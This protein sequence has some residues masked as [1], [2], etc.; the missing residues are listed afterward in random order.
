MFKRSVIFLSLS[1]FL[2]GCS[3]SGGLLRQEIAKDSNRSSDQISSI[4]SRT[5]AERMGQQMQGV[6]Y[7]D[8]LPWVSTKRIGVN[9]SNSGLP[10]WFSKS[11]SINLVDVNQQTAMNFMSDALSKVLGSTVSVS[12]DGDG[13]NKASSAAP[14][15]GGAN[16]VAAPAP[17]PKTS[18][19]DAALFQSLLSGAGTGTGSNA[20][21][22]GSSS[23]RITLKMTGSV[24]AVLDDLGSRMGMRWRFDQGVN[25][26]VFY[27]YETRQWSIT[28]FPGK[29]TTKSLLDSASGGDAGSGAATS[30][31]TTSSEFSLEVNA[32]DSLRKDIE[33]VKTG[34][35]VFSINESSGLLVARDT[36][37]AIERIDSVIKSFNAVSRNQVQIDISIYRVTITDADQR[38]LDWKVMFNSV[39]LTNVSSIAGAAALTPG[40]SLSNMA[41]K[42]PE[43]AQGALRSWTN[44]EAIVNMFSGFAKVNR[45]INTSTIALNNQSAPV[46]SG[47]SVT[48]LKSVSNNQVAL[49]GSSTSTTQGVVN[50]GLTLSVMPSIQEGG[51]D[52]MLQTMMTLTELNEMK[53]VR[54]GTT[55]L[56]LPDVSNREF[57][58]RAGMRSGETLV[59]FGF[60]NLDENVRNSSP[61]DSRFWMFGG[62]S[63]AKRDKESLLVI[64]T[65][66]IIANTATVR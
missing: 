56:G 24:R 38:S 14:A 50:T 37:D 26:V 60:E 27:K 61:L 49:S 19:G 21:A 58:Q 39:G 36:P 15:T 44:S 40:L 10:D 22:G 5:N 34:D 16:P 45:V 51:R 46:R 2:G 41:F 63:D 52:L 3:Q 1:V 62:S 20:G 42:I 7:Q 32:M 48:Y 13:I 11:V 57:I 28:T 33:S 29:F 23:S 30:S 55:D 54:V 47:R 8:E 31:G 35:G 59:L 9:T 65:P 18:G 17:E 64:I 43:T 25:K 6:L 4:Q 53:T 66:T 12:S